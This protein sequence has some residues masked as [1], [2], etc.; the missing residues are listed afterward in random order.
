MTCIGEPISWLRLECHAL[1]AEAAVTEHVAACPA[2]RHCLDELRGDLVA[3]PPLVVPERRRAFAWWRFAVPALAAAAIAIVV[4]RPR[5]EPPRHGQLLAGVKGLGDVTVELVRD[6]AGTI[7]HD[8]TGFQPGDRWK[9]VVT[10]AAAGGAWIDVA[11]TDGHATDHPL[12][13]VHVAC[14]NAVAVP[15]AFEITGDAPNEICARVWS[16]P[17]E[18]GDRACATITP[19]VR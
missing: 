15:G 7:A 19:E 14:G 18:L 17:G 6:R 13:P 1:A 5:P 4:L 16:A 2:C 9:V 8:A 12:A 10:C 11:V 3:L